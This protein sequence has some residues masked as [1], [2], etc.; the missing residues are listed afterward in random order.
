MNE[1]K[2]I[3]KDHIAYL[4]Q[5][6]DINLRSHFIPLWTADKPE[7]CYDLKSNNISILQKASLEN[8]F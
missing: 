2:N 7:A 4:W 8:N 6:W 1:R 5:S 3:T